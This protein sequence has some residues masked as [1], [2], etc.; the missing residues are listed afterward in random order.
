MCVS[1]DFEKY[2]TATRKMLPDVDYNVGQS[3]R[4]MRKQVPNDIDVP[5]VY[6]NA[7]HIFRITNFYTINSKLKTEV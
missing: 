1:Q 7:R 6:L 5:E 4:C 2:K 3:C